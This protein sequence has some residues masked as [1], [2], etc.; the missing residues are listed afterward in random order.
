MAYNQTGS[1][2]GSIPHYQ[3]IQ[4][5]FS[6]AEGV[7]MTDDYGNPMGPPPAYKEE[8][9]ETQQATQ[10]D[11]NGQGSWWSR[12]GWK[13]WAIVAAAI[14]V[15][16][17]AIVVPVELTKKNNS[18]PDYTQLSY[19]LEDTYSGT[20]F[21][22]N[23]EYF[24]G[25]DPSSGFVHYVPAT[26]A[27]STQYN[28]TYASSTSAVIKVDT[29]VDNST[30]PNAET[31]RFSVRIESKK[32]YASGLFIF[33]V[34]HAPLGCATWPALWLSDPSNW[35]TN[36]EIDIMEAVN[37]VDDVANQMTLH[38]SSGCSMKNVK[39][40]ETGSVDG[41]N[42]V[43]STSNDGCAVIDDDGF[44]FGPTFN[45]K[46]GGV[47]AMELRTEGIRMWDWWRGAIPA[48]I[49][50][51]T[52]DPST[53]K[54]ANADFPNTSCDITTHFKNQSII[55][56]IDLCGDWAGSA[57]IYSETCSGL[58][59]SQVAYNNTAFT[60]AYWEFGAFQVYTAS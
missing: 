11:G 28:M 47:I 5:P 8:V 25:Y 18:Y 17:V 33:D 24:T 44:T 57:S 60:D 31:G 51:G 4:N 43:N 22:D 21:F 30:V 6:D 38:T 58:C 53:W 20:S 34:I 41:T 27:N 9:T 3:Q 29:T 36:G 49:T 12:L 32:Q 48:D 13:K 2:L 26:T 16:I 40:K 50:A 37:V 19:T 7:H 10:G 1:E 52:P 54:T 46:G 15:L 59:T 23:F 39:R 55:A 42:C 45:S 35:P 14:A 56:N